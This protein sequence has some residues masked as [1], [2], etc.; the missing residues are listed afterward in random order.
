MQYKKDKKIKEEYPEIEDL[1]FK[2][3]DAQRTSKKKK[4]F[5]ERKFSKPNVK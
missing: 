4:Y 1:M 2:N 5:K 3:K